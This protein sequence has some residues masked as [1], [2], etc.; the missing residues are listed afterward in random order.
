MYNEFKKAFNISRNQKYTAYL[1]WPES[2]GQEIIDY[3]TEKLD[4]TIKGRIQ[5]AASR[6]GNNTKVLLGETSKLHKML[7]WSEQEYRARLHY[8]FG[9]TSRADLSAAQLANYVA[10]LKEEVDRQ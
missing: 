6:K 2:R 9:V 7:G 8:M 5:K 10:Y 4:N 3:L 1:L